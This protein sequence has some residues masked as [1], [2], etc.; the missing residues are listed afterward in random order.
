M[1]EESGSGTGA[2]DH[3][4]AAQLFAQN[5]S[6][7]GGICL[8]GF[9]PVR[10]ALVAKLADQLKARLP[11][12]RIPI[13][14]D[15]DRLLGGIDLS[16]TLRS[17]QTVRH[18]G[19]LDELKD[20][21]AIL[22]M[23]E[24]I[25]HRIAAHIAQAMDRG[26]LSVIMLDDG[27]ESD[28]HPP[29][30]LVERTA[31][32]CDLA[33]VRSMDELPRYPSIEAAAP[34]LVKRQRSALVATAAA[35]GVASMRALVFAE[36]CAALLASLRGREKVADEDLLAASRL[37]LA[38]RAT[39]MPQMEEPPG[40]KEDE[41]ER[42]DNDSSQNEGNQDI[43][44][45]PLADMMLEAV[46]STVPPNILD[47]MEGKS[48][49]QSRGQGGRSGQKQQSSR[50]GRPKGTRQ[51]IPGSG[52]R[53][54]LADTLRAAA[55]WQTIRRKDTGDGASGRLHIRKDDLRV[56]HYEE[57]QESLTIFAVDAS[58]SSALARLAEAKGAVELLLAQ[59]YVKR[60]QVALI[61]F[62][63][64]GAEVLLPPT[65]SLTRARRSLSALPGGG[66][67]PLA[68]GLLAARQMSE[69]AVKR[70]QAPTL[71]VLTDGKAN[72]RLDG[73]ADRKGA[74]EEAREVARSIAAAD[75]HALVIDISPRPRQEAAELAAWLNGKYVPL[76][77]AHSEAMVRA[78]EGLGK[79]VA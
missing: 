70:G 56:H 25:D 15:E 62:R 36:R 44:E 52:R 8:R 19:L 14:V 78:I 54:A 69:A 60:A 9:G 11:V 64:E 57:E 35:F 4:L 27:M 31:F 21:V 29:P 65:R 37:V 72:I 13:N 33:G 20:G 68:A 22:P 28:E 17:G 71:V 48:R 51:G 55:P 3:L 26:K 1:N 75:L 49:K 24:R 46:A 2:A 38:P 16:A 66:G 67:T 47:Q 34:R 53:L 42:P 10:D 12:A 58:G 50:R 61:A 30:R 76:P 7:F 74:M 6:I 39:Q 23:A 73:N 18:A 79:E 77:R 45:K 5:P 41:P 32:Q 43:S 63:Q 59:S 40:S